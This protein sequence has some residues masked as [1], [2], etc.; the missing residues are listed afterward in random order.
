MPAADGAGD[1]KGDGRVRT[2][3][4]ATGRRW[5]F[6]FQCSYSTVVAPAEMPVAVRENIALPEGRA[7]L[8]TLVTEDAGVP[9][10]WAAVSSRPCCLVAMPVVHGSGS[11]ENRQTRRWFFSS[12]PVSISQTYAL[13]V[14]AEF[15]VLLDD[16]TV[17]RCSFAVKR[18]DRGRK[19]S[20]TAKTTACGLSFSIETDARVTAAGAQD[21][22]ETRLIA[23]VTAGGKIIY[24]QDDR[25][26]VVSWE[27]YG[28][29]RLSIFPLH[30][31]EG[32]DGIERVPS[33]P[34]LGIASVS[35]CAIIQRQAPGTG[36]STGTTT[37][38][39]RP[40]TLNALRSLFFSLRARGVS[41]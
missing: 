40:H 39:T 16:G 37:Y 19:R 20:K 18:T 3:C 8:G 23:N 25:A 32:C 14:Q 38:G 11:D 41:H 24:A 26:I 29:P 10:T 6:D 36:V 30:L 31:P 13:T 27:H 1:P 21:H 34:L 2:Q 33:V 7:V 28:G 12:Q 4:K 22:G 5:H 15:V 17:W 9:R 35:C